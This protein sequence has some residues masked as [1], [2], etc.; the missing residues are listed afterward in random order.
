MKKIKKLVDAIDEELG[1]AQDYAESYVECKA[2]GE[3][4]RAASYKKM[5][6]DELDHAQRLHTMAVQEIKALEKIY[7]A[8]A[9]MQA[10]WDASH[11]T[12]VEKAAWIKQMLSL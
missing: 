4:D 1:G 7:T 6:Q 11:K 3:T 10:V 5:A 2:A 12:Y 8:P 9:D